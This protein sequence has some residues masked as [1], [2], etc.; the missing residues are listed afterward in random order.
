VSAPVLPY[1]VGGP[2]PINSETILEA[3][4][5]NVAATTA[6]INFANSSGYDADPAQLAQLAAEIA[7]VQRLEALGV[8][9]RMSFIG[10]LIGGIGDGIKSIGGAVLGGLGQVIPQLPTIANATA[11]VVQAVQAIQQSLSGNPTSFPQGGVNPSTGSPM[12]MPM[13]MPM[14]AMGMDPLAGYQMELAKA[15][16]AMPSAACSNVFNAQLAAFTAA[17]GGGMSMPIN[18][19]TG[20]PGVVSAGIGGDLAQLARMA[21]TNPTVAATLRAIGLGGLIGAGEVGVSALASA[22]FGSGGASG[23]GVRGPLLMQWPASTPYPR[24]IVLRAPDKPEKGYRSKGSALLMSGDVAAVRRVQKAATRAR[25]G[26][27]RSSSRQPTMLA[28]PASG[29][30]MVCGSCLSSPCG[31]NG[32]K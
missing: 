15:C 6:A 13:A 5:F 26:R 23:V 27:R 8:E 11:G 31:C 18:P 4:R 29:M 12:A 19:M 20:S 17:T 1:Y 32:G 3:A 25:R 24:G 30:R 7:E 10:D 16:G 21:L 9:G 2:G 22:A 14:S 28:L